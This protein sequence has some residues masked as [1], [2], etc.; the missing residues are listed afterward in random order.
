M[1]QILIDWNSIKRNVCIEFDINTTVSY[2]DFCKDPKYMVLFNDI[3][4]KDSTVST[5]LL[6]IWP[7]WYSWWI[8]QSIQMKVDLLASYDIV[9]EYSNWMSFEFWKPWCEGEVKLPEGKWFKNEEFDFQIDLMKHYFTAN[10][11]TLDKEKRSKYVFHNAI[12]IYPELMW[13]LKYA[14]DY[15]NYLNTGR[16]TRKKIKCKQDF[17]ENK[18]MEYAIFMALLLKEPLYLL[19]NEH[20]LS[21]YIVSE[22]N[23]SKHMGHF[24]LVQNISG[25]IK[26]IQK[27]EA[28]EWIEH[29]KKTYGNDQWKIDRMVVDLLDMI[30]RTWTLNV[31]LDIQDHNP[32]YMTGKFK[33]GDFDKY[34]E[35]KD[36]TSDYWYVAY[37]NHWWKKNIVVGEKE[38]KYKKKKDWKGKA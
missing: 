1:T 37:K 14:W 8:N 20:F 38:F 10:H 35:L 17:V 22:S 23:L 19:T 36:Y 30:K 7:W 28:L 24:A 34:S 33:T 29:I 18:R 3:K 9:E 25:F 31:S 12:L 2:E 26:Y 6:N 16:E 4:S 11:V 13:K 27:K 5:S 21:F 15:D 32:M